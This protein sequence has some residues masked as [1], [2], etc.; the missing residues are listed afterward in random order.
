MVLLLLLTLAGPAWRDAPGAFEVSV[1]ET[2]RLGTVDARVTYPKSDRRTPVLVFSHGLYGSKDGYE[3]LA[4]FWAAARELDAVAADESELPGAHEGDLE[5]LLREAG[6]GDVVE[7][8]LTVEV[9]HESFEEWWEPFTLGIGPAGAY[10]Q[11]LTPDARE[12]LR[13]RCRDLHPEAPFVVSAS[14]WAARG[15]V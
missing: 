4:R 6:L 2:I 14:A 1:L 10:V 3:P 15:V 11:G 13:E 7:T 5:R 12:R 9:G 8:L